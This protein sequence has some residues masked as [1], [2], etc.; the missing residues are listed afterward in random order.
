MHKT[1]SVGVLFLGI[2][3]AGQVFAAG[4]TTTTTTVVTPAATT[5]NAATSSTVVAAT[6]SSSTTTI[7]THVAVEK[8]VRDY[9]ADM[10]VM[11]AIARC[12]SN[13]RQFTDSG[14]PFRGGAGGEMV[15][16]FQ[17]YEQFHTAAAKA[18]GF[19][20]NTLEGNIGYAKHVY[21]QE[22]TTPWSACVPVTPVLVDAQTTL[23]IEL[24]TKLIGLLQQL[25][26]LE[27]AAR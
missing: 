24:L 23:K 18:L 3:F 5:T 12:E 26:A 13:F 22:G 7:L 20:L 4:V 11:I 25:L 6:S 2:L 1:I 27:L 17:F 9:F 10:P 15:G 8:Q 21:A 16:V 19:D 14:L